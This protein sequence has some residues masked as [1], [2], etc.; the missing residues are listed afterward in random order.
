MVGPPY[1]PSLLPAL[2]LPLA[3]QCSSGSNK[4]PPPGLAV[5]AIPY[6][7]TCFILGPVCWAIGTRVGKI[8]APTPRQAA[9]AVAMGHPTVRTVRYTV[10]GL[11]V[12]CF[13]RQAHTDMAGLP[14]LG[15][16]C[17]MVGLACVF[18]NMVG[19]VYGEFYASSPSLVN[20]GTWGAN[21]MALLLAVG[22]HVT[23][24]SPLWAAAASPALVMVL[25]KFL[26]S[27]CGALSGFGA[28]SQDIAETMAEHQPDGALAN[29]AANVGTAL[30]Y[31]ALLVPIMGGLM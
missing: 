21:T 31:Q 2:P 17:V 14:E 24:R 16:G 25:A 18:G 19:F 7:L 3:W 15:V 4:C 22:C 10:L 11:V 20:W 27:F 13:A 5:L 29:W 6:L 12:A 26:G 30:C 8:L 23:M 1:L 28:F 9:P